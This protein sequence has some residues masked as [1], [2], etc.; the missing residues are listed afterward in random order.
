ME[1]RSAGVPK[2]R[3]LGRVRP[4]PCVVRGYAPRKIFGNFACKS[5]HFGAF[6][7]VLGKQKDILTPVFLDGSL[8]RPSGDRRLCSAHFHF[9]L[10]KRDDLS[11]AL[12]MLCSAIVV[13]SLRL[14][15]TVPA[16]STLC[17]GHGTGIVR[18][19]GRCLSRNGLASSEWSAVHV[20]HGSTR[21]CSHNHTP[22]SRF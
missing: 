4:P 14:P 22:T 10:A 17:T 8:P 5:V 15:L 11:V 7:V 21:L 16:S 6:G 12:N 18:A 20:P 9:A 13:M 1:V 19:K 2:G 3:R